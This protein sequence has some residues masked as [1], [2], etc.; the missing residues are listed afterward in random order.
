MAPALYSFKLHTIPPN[1]RMVH[2]EYMGSKFKRGIQV[3]MKQATARTQ[4]TIEIG[5]TMN[6]LTTR[7]LL[8]INRTMVVQPRGKAHVPD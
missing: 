2:R 7:L 5:S 3:T 8:I 6:N 4:I 1:P